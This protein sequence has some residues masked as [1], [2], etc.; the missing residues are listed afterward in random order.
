MTTFYISNTNEEKERSSYSL[1]YTYRISNRVT[2]KQTNTN[3][4]S[5]HHETS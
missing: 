3:K 2:N 4:Y 5:I 1:V